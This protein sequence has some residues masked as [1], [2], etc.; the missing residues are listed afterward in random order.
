MSRD[1]LLVEVWG[2]A[3]ESA[4]ASLGVLLARIRRK[5]GREAIRTIRGQGHALG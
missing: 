1:A 3:S 2:E 5:L 4:S